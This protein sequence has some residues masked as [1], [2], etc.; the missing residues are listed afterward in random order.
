MSRP[1]CLSSERA[2]DLVEDCHVYH[3]FPACPK[4]KQIQTIFIPNELKQSRKQ[5]GLV[6]TEAEVRRVLMWRTTPQW[7]LS[8]EGCED[9]SKNSFVVAG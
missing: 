7:L 6:Y 3:F 1:E 9:P 2:E 5:L 4:E 8:P